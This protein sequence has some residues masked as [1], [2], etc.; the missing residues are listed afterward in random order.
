MSPA[1]QAGYSKRSRMDKLGVKPGMR[2]ALIG[3]EDSDFLA[4]LRER[5]SDI[6]VARPR[7]QSDLIFLGVEDAKPL[8]WLATLRR[9]IRPEGAIWT[10]WPK[11]QKHIGE[12]LIR[13]A[14]LAQGLVDVKVIAFS[15]RLSGL[16]LVIPLAQRRR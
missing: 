9:A 3:V 11:G 13:S 4:E 1:P 5:T 2:V 10:I 12:G 16:K 6:A 8:A 15:E 14:A 7:K